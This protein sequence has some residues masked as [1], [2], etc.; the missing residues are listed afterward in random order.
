[1]CILSFWNSVSIHLR[2]VHFSV[3]TFYFNEVFL[4]QCT[5][6]SLKRQ[7]IAP[8]SGANSNKTSNVSNQMVLLLWGSSWIP[9]PV[10][11][12]LGCHHNQVLVIAFCPSLM[13]VRFLDHSSSLCLSIT[14]SGQPEFTMIMLA[15]LSCY[16]VILKHISC[17]YFEFS[18]VCF[19]ILTLARAKAVFSG[20]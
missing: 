15:I 14:V 3:H 4:R 10:P 7:L 12:C 13:F 18:L 11:E 16:L 19:L 1:M 17:H 8:V 5:S 20:R 9:D 6:I 2:F